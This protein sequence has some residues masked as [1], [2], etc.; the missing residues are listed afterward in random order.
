MRVVPSKPNYAATEDGR[1]FRITP[2]ARFPQS[3][4]PAEMK[5]RMDRDGYMMCGP[6]MKV[7]RL[8]A[9]AFHQNP[10]AKPQVAHKN[11]VRNDNRAENLKWATGVENCADTIAH[12]KSVRGERNSF[13]KL[14]E[15][16]VRMA[17]L[18]AAQGFSHTDLAPRFGVDRSVLSRAIKGRTWAHV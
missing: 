8:V 2:C 16:A 15:E 18:L 9:E 14:T 13:A 11:G 1:I 17:R 12:G 7:H 5:Q 6:C 10:E 4:L 3:R